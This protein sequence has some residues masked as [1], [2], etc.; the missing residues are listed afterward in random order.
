MGQR[1]RTPYIKIKLSFWG[2][3]IV[4]IFLVMGQLD[5][6]C[7]QKKLNLGGTYIKLMQ[8]TNRYL[9]N[10]WDIQLGGL[11][12][13]YVFSFIENLQYKRLIFNWVGGA[14]T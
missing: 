6:C 13:R 9:N 7:P 12:C 8:I 5:V 11:I 14:V 4:S 2:A 10:N 1:G 3:S